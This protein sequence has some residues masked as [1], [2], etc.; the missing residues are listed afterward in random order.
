MHNV[1]SKLSVG[2]RA[3]LNLIRLKQEFDERDELTIALFES[4]AVGLSARGLAH[5]LRTHLSEIRQ[6]TSAIEQTTKKNTPEIL[7]HLRAIRSSCAAISSAASLID[8]MLP[9]TRSIK[10]K[11]E[12]A[13]FI[14]DYFNN[15]S[16]TYE[17][18][19]I[20]TNIF[21]N[22]PSIRANRP[23]LTQVFDNLVRNS[24]YWLNRGK[25]TGQL[26][27]PKTITVEL[28]PSGFVVSDSGPG[29][30]PNYEDSLF[31]I[32]VTAKPERDAGQGLG[33][34]IVSELLRID[35]CDISLLPD[36]NED[37]RRYRFAVNLRPVVVQ[38]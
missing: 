31:E 24:A 7:P 38:A 33:L 16:S 14:E 19:G 10:E 13:S 11:I 32:F 35:G 18:T 25:V 4:A 27:R 20:R 21:G 23:R 9:R 17:Q 29:V 3:G 26:D 6:R 15:R 37:G 28:S 22:G 1:Q 8:P 30:D 36:R 2:A 34:F 12:L 5:E